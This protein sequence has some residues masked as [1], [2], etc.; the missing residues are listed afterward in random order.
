MINLE[1]DH[2]VDLIKLKMAIEDND[3]VSNKACDSLELNGRSVA[4]KL[5][6]S[7]KNRADLLTNM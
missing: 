1:K 7:T 4:R 6:K 5:K 3:K 2:T